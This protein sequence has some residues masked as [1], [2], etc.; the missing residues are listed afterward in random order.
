MTTVNP[1]QS[2]TPLKQLMQELNEWVGVV[3]R[4]GLRRRGEGPD[5][6]SEVISATSELERF[7]EPAKAIV[8][9][10]ELRGREA[11]ARE[12]DEAMSDLRE[13]ARQYDAGTLTLP[14]DDRIDEHVGPLDVLI[15]EA[16]EAAGLLED[17]DFDLALE[18]WQ[19]FADA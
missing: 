10:L 1:L 5:D 13:V 18:T 2:P 14:Y 12:I 9:W 7:H 8:I 17:L 19:G 4:I 6:P 3:E 16:S 11:V 15:Q